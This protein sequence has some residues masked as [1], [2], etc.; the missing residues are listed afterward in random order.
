ME[1]LVLCGFYHQHLRLGGG[2]RE[3]FREGHS[4]WFAEEFIYFF[5]FLD[6]VRGAFLNDLSSLWPPFRG[7]FFFQAFSFFLF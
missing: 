5:M 2:R 6:H 7:H 3:A 4:E 1:I